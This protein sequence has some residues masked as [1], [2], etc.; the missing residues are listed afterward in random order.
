MT[1]AR[2][3]FILIWQIEKFV[4][5]EEEA[6]P[7]MM[8]SEPAK[9]PGMGGFSGVAKKEAPPPP[10]PAP[11][12]PRVGRYS[13]L[14]EKWVPLYKLTFKEEAEEEDNLFQM[15]IQNFVVLDR[16]ELAAE[17]EKEKG[18]DNTSYLDCTQQL[19]SVRERLAQQERQ[20]AGWRGGPG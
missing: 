3:N 12:R 16:P 5:A 9:K 8:I 1:C 14:N 13:H 20:P 10:K 6:M 2:E 17:M 19:Y 15:C 11:V 18:R 4:P 7:V